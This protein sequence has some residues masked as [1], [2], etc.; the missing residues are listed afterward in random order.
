MVDTSSPSDPA[1]V[2]VT[3]TASSQASST[4]EA[5]GM[6]G[7]S[8]FRSPFLAS[9]IQLD[10]SPARRLVKTDSLGPLIVAI[11]LDVHVYHI[12]KTDLKRLVHAEQ[13]V[14]GRR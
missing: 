8:M 9:G 4:G 11:Y 13:A 1:A 2:S 5:N 7:P 6:K 12:Q 10:I 14:L 3:L